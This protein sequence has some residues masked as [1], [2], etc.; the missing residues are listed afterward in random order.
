[1]M[2][3]LD[4]QELAVNEKGESDTLVAGVQIK[5][6]GA[7][8]GEEVLQLYIGFDAIAKSSGIDRPHK[9]LRGFRKI[10]L[11]PG[12]DDFASFE[13][14]INDLKRFDPATE[15][16]VL[17]KGEYEVMVG[18]SSSDSDLIKQCFSVV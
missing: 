16:W 10:K 3:T 2:L 8:A 9:L 4:T 12:E 5:N 1:M 11:E 6:T 15:T 14:S 7:L 18:T 17:D 13:L